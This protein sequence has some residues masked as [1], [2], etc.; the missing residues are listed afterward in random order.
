MK[1]NSSVGSL[2]LIQTLLVSFNGVLFLVLCFLFELYRDFPSHL[3]IHLQFRLT[4]RSSG[5]DASFFLP[6]TRV[7][8]IVDVLSFRSK[9]NSDTGFF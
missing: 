8:G 3:E 5:E 4:L 2:L 1:T 7:S 6:L 9:E